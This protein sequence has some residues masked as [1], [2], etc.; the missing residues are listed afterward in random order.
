MAI[1]ARAMET[2]LYS[3][4]NLSE[5]AG[6]EA[7]TIRSYIERDLL[8]GPYGLGPKAAYGQE[9]LDRLKVIR[10]LREADREMTL[11]RIRG[12]LGQ[13]PPEQIAALAAGEAKLGGE[14][15]PAPPTS[16]ALGYLM[17]LKGQTPVAQAAPRLSASPARS[18]TPLEELLDVLGAALPRAN[19]ARAVRSETWHRVPITPDVELSVRGEL[20]PDTLALLHRVGD[21]LRHLLM[22]GTRP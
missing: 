22:K 13:L 16:S 2:P 11:D 17:S 4:Q 19:V 9:H 18:R 10:L 7:R 8:P 20:D 1:Y 3:L 21:H 5:A 15:I 14:G 12:F 6:I